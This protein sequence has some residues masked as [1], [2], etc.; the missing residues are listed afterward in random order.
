MDLSSSDGQP[1]ALGLALVPVV[2]LLEAETELT[3]TIGQFRV[4]PTDGTENTSPGS[5]A[6]VWWFAPG[7]FEAAELSQIAEVILPF[8]LTA[9]YTVDPKGTPKRLR[10]D[11]SW[12]LDGLFILDGMD[13]RP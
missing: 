13:P 9:T 10:L 2:N 7:E 6:P 4:F 1:L 11:G 8:D 12:T 5:I 3:R